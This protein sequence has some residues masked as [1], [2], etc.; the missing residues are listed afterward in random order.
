MF[1][2]IEIEKDLESFF[3]IENYKFLG[4]PPFNKVQIKDV[5]RFLKVINTDLEFICES[6]K[7]KKLTTQHFRHTFINN[8]LK[9]KSFSEI[10]ED[11]TFLNRINRK[12]YL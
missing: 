2:D 7:W 10:E 9:N 4:C 3:T 1:V 12:T 5:G 11:Y 8:L 6:A